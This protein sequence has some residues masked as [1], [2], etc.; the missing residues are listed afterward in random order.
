M[1]SSVAVKVAI[2]LFIV[3]TIGVAAFVLLA[4]ASTGALDPT[5]KTVAITLVAIAAGLAIALAMLKHAGFT[6]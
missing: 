3:G 4:T 5:V 1:A 6:V 2:E